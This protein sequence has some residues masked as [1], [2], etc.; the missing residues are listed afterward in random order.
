MFITQAVF[1]I[2]FKRMFSPW[3]YLLNFTTSRECF[4]FD[5]KRSFAGLYINYKRLWNNVLFTSVRV[6]GS[7][8][9]QPSR[10]QP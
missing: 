7:Y 8:P 9:V 6:I 4:F 1:R 5:V 3:R 10:A 2:F